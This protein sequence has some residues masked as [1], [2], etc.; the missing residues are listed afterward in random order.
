[1]GN[2]AN[3]GW[4]FSGS[5][6]LN[7]HFSV[8]G[9]FSIMNTVI[10]DSTGDYLSGQLSGKAPGFRLKFLPHHTAGIFLN[11]NTS[12]IFGRKNRADIS[13]NI[14]EL[15]GVYA[16]DGIRFI[17]D[18]AYGRIDTNAPDFISNYYI[19]T[20]TV[21]QLGLNID[22]YLNKDLRI[23]IQGSNI[24]NNYKQQVSSSYPTSGASWMFG[25]KFNLVRTN[26]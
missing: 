18:L 16:F 23:F 6:K 2:V 5:Y 17:T 12:K 13:L 19:T 14:T 26:Q 4:E 24:T 21:F 15:D 25:I 8:N 22:Y 7:N 20:G 10:K 1:V 11:Y 9:T 3:T